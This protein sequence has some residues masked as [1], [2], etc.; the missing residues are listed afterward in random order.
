VRGRPERR[1][2]A[3]H[4]LIPMNP[5]ISLA[6]LLKD[7]VAL[8]S[9]NP[10]FGGTGEAGVADYVAAFLQRSGI[11]PTR[12]PVFPGG[13]DNVYARMGHLP[14]PAVLLEAH[15]DTVDAEGWFSGDPFD[16]VEKDGRL[17]G[18]GACDTKASLAVLL[19]VAAHFAS[20]PEELRRPFVF[21]A[22]IDEEEK[23]TG[24]FRLM[25]AGLSLD[26][27]I[28]GEPTLLDIV[29]AH[30]GCLRFR[31]RTSGRA[32]HGAFPELGDNA[33]MRMGRVLS[34]L[35][36]YSRE[37]ASRPAHPLLGKPT[38]NV[39]TIRGGQSANVVPDSCEIELDRRLL[40]DEKGREAIEEIE[41][42]LAGVEQAAIEPGCQER[43]GID[44]SPEAPLA[45]DLAKAAGDA[46]GGGRFRSAPYMTN[47]AAY[48]AAG[49]PS[50]VF[51]PGDIAQAHTRD[52]SVELAQLDE[53][54]RILIRFLGRERPKG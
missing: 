49:L 36:E 17:Y 10:S 6:G 19:A 9:V 26:G 51:G 43:P 4:K 38:L 15:M 35:S 50:L 13:R 53:A 12:Q 22:T 3:G 1:R 30:K 45:R 23:Q 54:F 32:A 33:V 21:A 40:P 29:H 52:E 7:L 25:E 47:A 28:T 27:A 11:E 39:G 48:V 34:L 14:G 2:R 37:L 42:L 5:S 44:T 46:S 24:A 31:I 18:R 20:R 41:N 8:P 16:P